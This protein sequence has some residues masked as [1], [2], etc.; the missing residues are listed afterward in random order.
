MTEITMGGLTQPKK[1]KPLKPL[2]KVLRAVSYGVW[3]KQAVLKNTFAFFRS[4]EKSSQ[5]KISAP[6]WIL[7]QFIL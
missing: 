3:S 7:T 2:K 5:V 1:Q 4:E 6:L